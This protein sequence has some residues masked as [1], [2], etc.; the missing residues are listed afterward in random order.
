MAGPHQIPAF[1]PGP[2]PAYVPPEVDIDAV[3]AQVSDGGVSASSADLPQLRQVVA[4][5]RADGVDLKI[6]VVDINLPIDTPLRDIATVVGQANPGSTVLV[7]SRAFAGTYS[8]TFDRVLLEAGE[9]VAKTGDPVQSA[10]NFVSQLST[11]IFPW[12]EFTVILTL[13]V[14]LAAVATRILQVR[15]KRQLTAE[16]TPVISR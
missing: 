12:T 4:E 5:A 7:M 15:S 10:Q 14:M 8:P 11:P 3:K 6:V 2:F 1:V 13:A 16:N 9:D